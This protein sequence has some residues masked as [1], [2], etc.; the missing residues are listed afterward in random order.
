MEPHWK[1][2]GDLVLAYSALRQK[3]SLLAIMEMVFRCTARDRGLAFADIATA[4]QLPID[5]VGRVLSILI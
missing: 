5:E 3:I 2:E 4:V 1:Q